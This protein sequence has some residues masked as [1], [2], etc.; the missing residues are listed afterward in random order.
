MVFKGYVASKAKIEP[1]APAIPSTT[2]SETILLGLRACGGALPV[3][4]D[5][6]CWDARAARKG[7][8]AAADE[9]RKLR[10]FVAKQSKNAAL[11]RRGAKEAGSR[12]HPLLTRHRLFVLHSVL[13]PALF[14]CL[15]SECYR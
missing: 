9:L 10:W 6:A 3:G 4:P 1:D 5:R 8:R 2:A 13:R 7:G 12:S 14:G 11:V 15:L